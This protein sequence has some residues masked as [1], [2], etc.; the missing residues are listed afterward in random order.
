ML[1]PSAWAPRFLLSLQEALFT[2]APTLWKPGWFLSLSAHKSMSV[3]EDWN[4]ILSF[5]A[6][7]PC[8]LQGDYL[9]AF[10]HRHDTVLVAVPWSN[11][12]TR[13]L[14]TDQTL[15][16]YFWMHK[17]NSNG[18]LRLPF[19]LAMLRDGSFNERPLHV[20]SRLS[21]P[22]KL[23]E[24]LGHIWAGSEPASLLLC[25]LLSK[26]PL[27][28]CV[29]LSNVVISSPMHTSHGPPMGGNDSHLPTVCVSD[30][31][32]PSFKFQFIFS[33]SWQFFFIANL[34]GFRTS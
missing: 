14:C 10:L 2:E 32:C 23:C 24:L 4:H 15:N 27:G 16:K 25:V 8:R 18:P 7:L 20:S 17:I 3:K 5:L 12:R 34:T 22:T 1:L 11:D 9:H 28:I 30:T 13:E 19:A 6:V 29:V 31:L 33:Y 21:L 26:S